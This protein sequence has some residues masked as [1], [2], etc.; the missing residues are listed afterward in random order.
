MEHRRDKRISAHKNVGIEYPGG[1]T[2]TG[3][4][5]NVSV[6]GM[7][8]EFDTADLPSHALVQLLLS[9]REGELGI[10]LQIPAAITR[11]LHNGIGLLYCSRDDHNSKIIRAWLERIEAKMRPTGFSEGLRE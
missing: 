5:K 2:A 6:G 7:F 4:T 9:I 3:R 10:H 1:R 11:R 8:V